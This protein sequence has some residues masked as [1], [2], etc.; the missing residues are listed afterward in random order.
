MRAG[1]KLIALGFVAWGMMSVPSSASI[2]ILNASDGFSYEVEPGAFITQPGIGLNGGNG[3]VPGAGPILGTGLLFAIGT[4]PGILDPSAPQ[5]SD[6]PHTGPISPG[7]VATNCTA[8][9]SST[10]DILGEQTTHVPL[11]YFGGQAAE[12][13]NLDI[14]VTAIIDANADLYHV[15]FLSWNRDRKSCLGDCA[16]AGG[17][18]SFSIERVSPVPTPATLPLFASGLAGLGWLSRRRCRRTA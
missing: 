9:L 14:Q 1:I 3:G 4:P 8:D 18:T 13:I 12:F 11:S 7:I 6:P 5:C 10:S 17:A 15:D 2:V 16:A